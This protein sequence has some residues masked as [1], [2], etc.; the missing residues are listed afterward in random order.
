MILLL[1]S[2]RSGTSWIG[3]VFDSHPDVQARIVHILRHPC[4]QIASRLRGIRLKL[5]DGGTYIRSSAATPQARR[6]GFDELTLSILGRS[7]AFS[8]HRTA[9]IGSLY[10]S[11]ASSRAQPRRGA[12]ARALPT[13]ADTQIIPLQPQMA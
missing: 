7:R 11:A 3:K 6:M 5:L 10:I 13:M 1:G 8:G 9:E 4:G 12:L 2:P